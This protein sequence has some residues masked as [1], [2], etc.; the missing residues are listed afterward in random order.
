MT[1]VFDRFF[2]ALAMSAL[3]AAALA[4][5][6]VAQQ[7]KPRP[8][9]TALAGPAIM[10]IPGVGTVEGVLSAAD[11]ARYQRIFEL[12][13]DGQWRAAEAVV[14]RLTNPLLLG[15]VRAQKFLHPTAY[16]SR[17]GELRD[18]LRDHADHPQARRIHRLAVLRQ[19][20]GARAP[21][22]PVTHRLS[23]P[24]PVTRKAYEGRPL[25]TRARSTAARR[26]QSEIMRR[27]SRGWPTGAKEMIR[28]A[29]ARRNLSAEQIAQGWRAIARGY[30]RA[31]K[32]ADALDAALVSLST[33]PGAAPLAYWWGGLAA[34]KLDRMEDAETL[35]AELS[36]A[37]RAADSL[38]A[39]GSF[40]AARAALAN[41]N[42]ANVTPFLETGARHLRT[43]Y[44]QLSAHALGDDRRYA[45]DKPAFGLNAFRDVA[46]TD[47][48][49][50][51]IG[52]LQI[53]RDHDAERELLTL[54]GARPHLR[55]DI[56]GLAAHTGLPAVSLKLSGFAGSDVRLAAAY[57]VPAWEP[58]SGYSVDRAL[59]LAFVRQESAFNRRAESRAGARG[60]MQLMPRTASYVGGERALRGR[61]KY[62]LYEPDLNLELGQRYVTYLLGHRRV[63]GDLLRLVAA[64]NAGP[65][66]LGAWERAVEHGDDP[67]L[68]IESLP[69]RETR[70]FVEQILTNL[71]L[72]R[73]QLGQD[74][75]SLD[76]LAAGRWPAYV[77]QD[78]HGRN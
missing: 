35:F 48:G 27:V 34:W 19:P 43:F 56:L 16:R 12:Q 31:G 58:E 59:V 41:G 77:P 7:P 26:T 46:A 38:V 61:G 47:I 9:E 55:D 52:L 18:W 28:S 73:N 30:F 23:I 74:T 3:V 53:G 37:E 69:S 71:W 33:A 22:A 75:P 5:A 67:L 68:F 17:Y 42:P 50:R 36:R 66:N 6:A 21:A 13:D 72:Y 39:A 49:A 76:A 60:L 25:Y 57:P 44:G 63:S 20:K 62:R 64:Y 8:L 4:P 24:G 14:R 70:R 54:A 2:A 11:A 15:H 40:W 51:A 1:R 65:G 45:W 29:E 32:H 10:N 78:R